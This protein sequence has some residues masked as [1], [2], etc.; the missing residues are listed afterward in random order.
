MQVYLARRAATY[1]LVLA[2]ALLINFFLPRALPGSPLVE[3][4]SGVGS[5][6]VAP[7]P[8]TLEALERYYGLDRSLPQQF[9]H[10]LQGLFRGDWGFSIGYKT[11]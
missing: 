8:A 2:A 9:G 5:L 11:P 7:D 6:A 3:L 4:T 10:Y 1:L